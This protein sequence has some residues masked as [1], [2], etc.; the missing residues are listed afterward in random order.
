MK[1]KAFEYILKHFSAVS[2]TREFLN[3]TSYNLVKIL[4][5]SQIS[6]AAEEEVFEAA[7]RWIRHNDPE[8]KKFAY[9]VG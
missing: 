6:V 8:H 3:L 9:A 2:A 5:S 1:Q 4:R 7:H